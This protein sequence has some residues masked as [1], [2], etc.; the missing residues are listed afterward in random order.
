MREQPVVLIIGG[1]VIGLTSAYFLAR[2]GVRVAVFDRSDLGREASWAGAGIIPPGNPERTTSPVEKLRALSSA[3][4]ADFSARLREE[5]GIDNGYLRCGGVEFLDPAEETV[6]D[7]WREEGIRFERLTPPA[8][9]ELEP[10]VSPP[11]AIPYHLPDMAQVRN[12]R[13]LRALIAACERLGVELNPGRGVAS[14][15]RDGNRIRSVRL[16]SGEVREGGAFLLAAGAW[17]EALLAEVGARVGVHPVRGQIVLFRSPAPP[18]QRIL[19]YGKKYLVPRPDGR[20]L[21]GSTEEPE[22][23]FEKA[24]T[25]GAVRHL[26]DL[27]RRWVP[28]LASA[29][30][31]RTWAGLRPGSPDGLPF[32]GKVPGWDNLFVSTGHFR[33]GLQL[34]VASGKAVADLIR[35]APPPC[36]VDPFRPDRAPLTDYRAAFRS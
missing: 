20:T 34:S 22:A 29:E 24:N 35:G 3:M 13:H 23:G 5:T 28:A 1:G 15:E 18:I 6:V 26:T 25:T 33:A 19:L 36:P 4:W 11:S 31:E 7:A 21:A 16:E 9:A 30:V 8:L 12:P 14:L 27:A 10:G 2:E 32:L 17:S